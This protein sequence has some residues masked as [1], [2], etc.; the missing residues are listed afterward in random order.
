MHGNPLLRRRILWCPEATNAMHIRTA[1]AALLLLLAAC[2]PRRIPDTDIPDTRD[3]RAILEVLRQYR[4]ATEK[5]DAQ[6]LLALVSPTFHDDAGTGTP[7]D[8]MDYARL[9]QVLPEKLAALKDVQLELSVRRIDVEGDEATAVFYYTTS[10]LIPGVTQ[11]AQSDS[12]LM[13]MKLRREGGTWKIR[14]GL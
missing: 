7:A 13:E 9:Q 8:D 4:E 14:S 5:R 6:A 10:Y 11:K 2:A 1:L 12:D 3:T